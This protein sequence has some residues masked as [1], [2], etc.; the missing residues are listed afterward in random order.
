MQRSPTVNR[1]NKIVKRIKYNPEIH[2]RRSIRIKE[3]D[4][5]HEGLY[6]ITICTFNHACLFGHLDNGDVVLT[7]Y[8]EIA[9]TEWLKTGELRSNISLHEF[10]MMPNHM[11]GIIEI[12]GSTCRGT[13]PRAL[14]HRGAKE[15]GTLQRAPTEQFGKPTSNTIP[16]IVR[17]FKSTVTKQIN[18]IRNTSG[19]SVWQRS[20]YE[21]VIR[22]EKSYNRIIEYIRYNPKKW[23]KDKYYMD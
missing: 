9:N 22:N 3:Y 18:D 21:H 1:Y 14:V 11:H 15:E 5:S 17:G 16:T 6:F 20:Y 13:I 2:H 4:Y 23:L 19:Q 12:D 7:A 10:V 8:G